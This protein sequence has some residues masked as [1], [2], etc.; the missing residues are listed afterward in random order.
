M[1]ESPQGVEARIQEDLEEREQERLLPPRTILG[2]DGQAYVAPVV[3]EEEAPPVTL[4]QYEE[5]AASIIQYFDHPKFPE[6]GITSLIS[7]EGM[8]VGSGAGDSEVW[9]RIMFKAEKSPEWFTKIGILCKI[10]AENIQGSYPRKVSLAIRLNDTAM[11]I[12][13]EIGCFCVHLATNT[14]KPLDEQ[15]PEDVKRVY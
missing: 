5:I 6:A 12:A 10:L 3:E 13:L 4:R 9:I 15:D 7:T 1:Y 8:D 11:I 14:E 2:P